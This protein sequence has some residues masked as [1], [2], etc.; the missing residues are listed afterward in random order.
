MVKRIMESTHLCELKMFFF[1][2]PFHLESFDTFDKR[3]IVCTPFPPEQTQIRQPQTHQKT[4][5]QHVYKMA[6][7]KSSD[8]SKIYTTCTR[9]T[10]SKPCADSNPRIP[11][12]GRTRATA[13]KA[14]QHLGPK[15]SWEMLGR[16]I[17]MVNGEYTPEN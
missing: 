14:P 17:S 13:S 12:S 11:P 4:S 10:A 16:W 1:K 6:I 5:K 3:T 2:H 7:L 8:T 15:M 9:H